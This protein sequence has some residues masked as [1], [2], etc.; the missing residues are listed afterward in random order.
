MTDVDAIIPAFN[1]AERVGSVI[2]VLQQ[3]GL[4][5]KILVVDDG[6]SDETARVATDHGVGAVSHPENM[7]KARAMQ[8]GLKA[9]SAPIVC[10]ID[11]DLIEV[12]PDHLHDLVSPVTQ[13]GE[14]ATLAVFSGGRLTTTLAQK[15]APMISGQRCLRREL[16]DDFNGWDSKFGIET[17]IN[18]HLQ[19]RGIEQQ[20][21]QWHG[22]GQVMKEEKRGLLVGVIAR[23]GMY[24]DIVKAWARNR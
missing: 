2:G 5:D 4:F 17:E 22:A 11:A 18:A 21:V 24:R 23:L 14:Q 8:T 9:T 12:T 16:L 7:G 20:I 15:V 13:G 1:E 6:S 19:R 3:S 10:F